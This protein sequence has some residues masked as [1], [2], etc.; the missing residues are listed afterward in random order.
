M[1][2]TIIDS[3]SV[4]LAHSLSVGAGSVTWPST[5]TYVP[6]AAH[7]S[8]YTAT[9]NGVGIVGV[10]P[11]EAYTALND[12]W[13]PAYVMLPTALSTDGFPIGMAPFATATGQVS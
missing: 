10:S 13:A 1:S 9:V 11:A 5:S 4:T 12:Q 8:P 6:V 3:D 7:V 2:F